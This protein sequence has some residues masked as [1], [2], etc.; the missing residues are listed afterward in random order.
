MGKGLTHRHQVSAAEQG[1]VPLL[2]S[3]GS[4]ECK[5]L[6]KVSLHLVRSPGFLHGLSCLLGFPARGPLLSSNRAPW[7]VHGSIG[8]NPNYLIYFCIFSFW[9]ILPPCQLRAKGAW[10]ML[11]EAYLQLLEQGSVNTGG[12]AERRWG[13]GRERKGSFLPSNLIVS[14]TKPQNKHY[15]E[16]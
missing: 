13:E 4:A 3:P 11:L 2:A 5:L 9:A 12:R 15:W 8:P 6:P 1:S 7:G 14:V 10:P 16:V